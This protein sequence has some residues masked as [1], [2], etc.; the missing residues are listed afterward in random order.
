VDQPFS[1][2]IGHVSGPGAPHPVRLFVDDQGRMALTCTVDGHGWRLPDA[3]ASMPPRSGADAAPYGE[4]QEGSAHVL[5]PG[6]PGEA[7]GAHHAGAH[8][9]PVD[10]V[11][12]AR[13]LLRS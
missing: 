4:D 3:V 7:A 9:S 6:P 13:A 2:P 11:A 1:H 5:E 8:A 10:V 12:V